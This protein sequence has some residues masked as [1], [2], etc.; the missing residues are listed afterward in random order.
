MGNVVTSSS[1][2]DE[3]LKVYL[4]KTKDSFEGKWELKAKNEQLVPYFEVIEH[5]LIKTVGTGSFGRVMVCNKKGSEDFM[6]V[7][8]LSKDCIIEKDQVLSILYAVH[9]IHMIQCIS[10]D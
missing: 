7:K 5:E 9:H 6:A 3:D 2:E 10:L 8:C 4:K 1:S